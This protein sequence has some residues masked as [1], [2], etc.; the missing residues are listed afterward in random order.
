MSRA[1]GLSLF[2]LSA[3][4]AACAGRGSGP[5]VCPGTHWCGAA[6][7]VEPLA[8]VTF[9]ETLTCPIHISAVQAQGEGKPLPASMPAG[10]HGRLDEKQTKKHRDGGDAATCCYQWVDPCPAG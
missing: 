4:F 1:V 3:V 9:G 2:V 10:A 5:T 7:E 6:A 8:E